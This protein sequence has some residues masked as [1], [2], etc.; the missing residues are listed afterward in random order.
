MIYFLELALHIK[1]HV[2]RIYVY[3]SVMVNLKHLVKNLMYCQD[4]VKQLISTGHSVG[5]S[6]K[7]QKLIMKTWWA[8]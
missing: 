8:L 6:L 2:L 4:T 5:F 1:G 7:R 3:G